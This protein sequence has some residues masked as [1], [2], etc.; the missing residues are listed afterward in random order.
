MQGSD[1]ER[2]SHAPNADALGRS[3]VRIIFRN[4][5]SSVQSR[6]PVISGISAA[7]KRQ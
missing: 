6:D 4:Y 7:R 5:I 3:F 2:V 1:F